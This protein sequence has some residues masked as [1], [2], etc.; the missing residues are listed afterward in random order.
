MPNP[1]RAVALDKD[2]TLF[3]T[4]AHYA[5]ALKAELAAAGAHLS[6]EQATAIIGLDTPR[7]FARLGQL[8]PTLDLA[9]LQEQVHRHYLRLLGQRVDFM[10][11]APELIRAIKA[12]GLP[13]ALVSSDNRAGVE[14]NF[15]HS[16]APELLALFDL[17]IT[18]EDV[19][20]PKPSPEPYQKVMERFALAPAE[21]LVVEDSV[22]GAESARAAGATVLCYRREPLAGCAAIQNLSEALAWL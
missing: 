18:L 1:I 19:A 2:G 22:L 6:P 17:I 16:A 13:L 12:R 3:N 5:A 10:A 7:T 20:A 4:E 21:L 14:H 15:H 9:R 8:F 11:G